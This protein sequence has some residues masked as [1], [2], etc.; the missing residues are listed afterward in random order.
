MDITTA[1]NDINAS[2]QPIWYSEQTIIDDHPAQQEGN[3]SII[4]EKS[5]TTLARSTLPPIQSEGPAIDEEDDLPVNQPSLMHKSSTFTVESSMDMESALSDLEKENLI[6]DD[7]MPSMTAPSDESF[8]ALEQLLGLG[9]GATT[10]RESPK[11]NQ[12]TLSLTVVTPTDIVNSTRRSSRLS[13]AR[14]TITD[15]LPSSQEIPKMPTIESITSINMPSFL[16]DNTTMADE[17][18]SATINQQSSLNISENTSKNDDE[19]SFSFELNDFT[20]STK[21]ESIV[22]TP[23]P[24]QPMPAMRAPTCADVAYRALVKRRVSGR[25]SQPIK[26]QSPL[27]GPSNKL[28]LLK[29]LHNIE[30]ILDK[31]RSSAPNARFLRSSCRRISNDS[32]PQSPIAQGKS[33][34][35]H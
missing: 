27:A 25:V 4:H 26:A 20:N 12:D 1:P 34:K 17:Q 21:N 31:A 24:V 5:R 30:C 35:K 9:S 19:S 13:V 23:Q 11:P 29:I 15:S 10:M 6:K 33:G 8:R 3:S 32:A 22:D 18:A 2:L 14:K 28:Q 7:P 16:A